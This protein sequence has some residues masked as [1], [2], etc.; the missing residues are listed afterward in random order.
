[1]DFWSWFTEAQNNPPF[2]EGE[3][4]VQVASGTRMASLLLTGVCIETG[5]S[6]FLLHVVFLK[7]TKPGLLRYSS[8]TIT[9]TC[10]S[11]Q[12]YVLAHGHMGA[13]RQAGCR[14]FPLP[15]RAPLLA[16]NLLSLFPRP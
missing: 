3:V 13:Q 9:F 6:L 11:V 1:M 4:G 15:P 8:R 2:G 5:I 7:I 16:V 10:F 12:G 14:V